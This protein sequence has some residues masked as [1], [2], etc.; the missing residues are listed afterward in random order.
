MQ[1]LKASLGCKVGLKTNHTRILRSAVCV[2][3]YCATVIKDTQ[4]KGIQ[5]SKFTSR[6]SEQAMLNRIE[7]SY[8]LHSPKLTWKPM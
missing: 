3:F 7:E 4:K 6:S 5:G 2:T 1:G 8:T